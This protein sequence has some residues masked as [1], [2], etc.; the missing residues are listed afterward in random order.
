MFIFEKGKVVLLKEYLC[1][2]NCRN[3]KFV[4]ESNKEESNPHSCEESKNEGSSEVITDDDLFADEDEELNK[5]EQIFNFVEVP[6]CY[7]LELILS[8]FTFWKLRKKEFLMVRSLILAIIPEEIF[9]ADVDINENM[10][11]DI[12]LYNSLIQKAKS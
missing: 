12:N 9:A 1:D 2:C 7:S 8:L 3:F 6:S 5:E 10:L 11:F 4:E